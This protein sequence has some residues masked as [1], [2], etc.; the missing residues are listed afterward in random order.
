MQAEQRWQGSVG[1]EETD[2][3]PFSMRLR[4]ENS[5]E[6]MQMMCSS[7]QM[8]YSVVSSDGIFK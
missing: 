6:F 7:E 5:H 2:E 4:A 1:K 3:G 8:H